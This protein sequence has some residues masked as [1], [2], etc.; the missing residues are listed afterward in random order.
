MD[1][2]FFPR[3]DDFRQWLK[4]N[5]QTEDELWVGFYKKATGIPSITWP[6][7][8][9]EALCFGWI[10]GLRKSIDEKSYKI[11]FT[12]RRR[13]SNWSQ[14]NLKMMEKLIENGKIRP[15]GLKAYERRDQSKSRQVSYELDEVK[16]KKEYVDQI[17]ENPKAWKFFNNLPPGYKKQTCFYV[18]QAKREDTRQRRL[19]V[20]IESAAEGKKIPHLRRK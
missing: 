8:V 9:E 6:E 17:K 2:K 15:A 10:D 11:R 3:P 12:P 5:H 18:M 16:L 19:K 20:L 4:E 7:S 1:P 13:D 14:V